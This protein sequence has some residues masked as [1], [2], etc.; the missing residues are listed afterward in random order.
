MS[1]CIRSVKGNLAQFESCQSKLGWQFRLGT[2]LQLYWTSTVPVLLC[3]VF[4]HCL[5]QNAISDTQAS[6]KVLQN[7]MSGFHRYQNSTFVS[8]TLFLSTLPSWTKEILLEHKSKRK[9]I[10]EK[11]STSVLLTFQYTRRRSQYLQN[12]MMHFCT[13]LPLISNS[14]ALY[15]RVSL[16]L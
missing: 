8:L 14:A 10:S 3:R 11:T 12:V 6:D 4:S 16:V 1:L 5:V 13:C 7:S 15:T 9:R 2:D